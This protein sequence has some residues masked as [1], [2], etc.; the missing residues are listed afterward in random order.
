MDAYYYFFDKTGVPEIDLIL[1]AVACAGKA[2][3][4]T[5]N[6]QNET[7]PSPGHTGKT[8][9]EWIQNAADKAATK[10]NQSLEPTTQSLRNKD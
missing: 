9:E 2:Y 6:W 8:P 7:S 1:S 3:H 4:H 10:Y 5:E